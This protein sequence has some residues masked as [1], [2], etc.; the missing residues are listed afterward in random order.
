MQDKEQSYSV[1]R[2]KRMMSLL[3]LR[4]TQPPSPRICQ[5][6]PLIKLRCLHL[7]LILSQKRSYNG[8]V[9][10]AAL[11]SVLPAAA[12]QFWLPAES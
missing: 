1:K 2:Q 11:C 9:L 3:R 6:R 10:L 12:Y 5:Q 4:V 7:A 8:V